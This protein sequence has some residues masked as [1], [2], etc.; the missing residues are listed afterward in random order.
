MDIVI[1]IEL[2]DFFCINYSGQILVHKI[3]CKIYIV[4]YVVSLLLISIEFYCHCGYCNICQLNYI[5]HRIH[6]KSRNTNRIFHRFDRKLS[7]L[8]NS[9]KSKIKREEFAETR[10]SPA[11]EGSRTSVQFR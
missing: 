9:S 3:P 1:V 4:F 5:K 7:S 10:R 2:Y 6:H 11:Y 8:A